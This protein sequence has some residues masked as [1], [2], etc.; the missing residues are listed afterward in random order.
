MYKIPSFI[1]LVDSSMNFS[2]ISLNSNTSSLGPIEKIAVDPKGC[3]L[4][5]S[6]QHSSILSVFSI[7]NSTRFVSLFVHVLTD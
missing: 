1:L 3:R 7:D 6:H 4:V 5:C 2:T